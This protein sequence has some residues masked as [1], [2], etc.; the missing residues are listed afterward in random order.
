MNQQVSDTLKSMFQLPQNRIEQF[1]SICYI[2]TFKKNEF[3]EV[4]NKHFNRLGYIL[5]GATRTFFENNQGDEI[6]YLLQVNGDV[7]GDYASFITN[8]K[9]QVKIKTILT[10]EMLFFEKN[11][12]DELI[13][14]DIFWL[15]FAKRLSD[16]AFLS[17]KQ[18]LDELFLYTP[19][20]RYL[21]LLNKSHEIIQKFRKNIFHH[22]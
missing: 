7:I 20:L 3:I 2:H 11:H 12:L 10:T 6:S 9:A 16:L 22:I 8:E 4:K 13:Q 5:N 18:R 19:E 21:N 15:A 14:N 1:L 17:A